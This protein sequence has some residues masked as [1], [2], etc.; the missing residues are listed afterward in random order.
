MPAYDTTISSDPARFE[1]WVRVE[2]QGPEGLISKYINGF[3]NETMTQ[4]YEYAQ[5]GGVQAALFDLPS[6]I[7]EIRPYSDLQK[8]QASSLPDFMPSGGSSD[9]SSSVAMPAPS[10]ST[11]ALPAP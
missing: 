2:L 3:G 5:L 11:P 4:I 10:A 1:L 8:S 6:N 9:S 7:K